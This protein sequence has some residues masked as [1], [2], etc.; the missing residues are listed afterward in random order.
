MHNIGRLIANQLNEAW[1]FNA[2]I[3][4]HVALGCIATRQ[5]LI[6]QVLVAPKM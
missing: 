1:A 6:W 4:P 5:Q 3:M 2:N